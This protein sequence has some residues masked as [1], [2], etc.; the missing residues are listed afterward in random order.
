MP[1][2][3]ITVQPLGD[4]C[5]LQ[6][7]GGLS[8]GPALGE[9]TEK[10]T[11]VLKAQRPAALLCDISAVGSLDSAGLGELVALYV[12]GIRHRIPVLLVGPAPRTQ[13]L[14]KTTR[15]DGILPSYA[16]PAEALRSI[17]RE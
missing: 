8:L 3:R 12:L 9:L 14:L 17:H 10:A 16:T 11:E 7:Y 5:L 1:S 2:L 13:Q 15:L 4:A 6:V